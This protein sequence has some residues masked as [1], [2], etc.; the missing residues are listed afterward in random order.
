[1]AGWHGVSEHVCSKCVHIRTFWRNSSQDIDNQN[2]WFEW[3]FN[4][5]MSAEIWCDYNWLCVCS[6]WRDDMIVSEDV[7]LTKTMVSDDDLYRTWEGRD[8]R[9]RSKDET[10]M[11][12]YVSFSLVPDSTCVEIERRG[13]DEERKRGDEERK[14][15]DEERKRGDEGMRREREERRGWG[16]KESRG[17]EEKREERRRASQ[18][19]SL[20]FNNVISVVQTSWAGHYLKS[21]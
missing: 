20:S 17:G 8:E 15:G 6:W 21:A 5:D 16:E 12:L 10:F 7:I 1:M 9:G 2:V 18:W 19:K 13:G 3:C 11:S 14:R 4:F